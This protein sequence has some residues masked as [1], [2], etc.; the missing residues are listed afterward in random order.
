[1]AQVGYYC[2]FQYRQYQLKEETRKNLFKHLPEE[3]FSVFKL[4][5]IQQIIDWKGN[6]EFSLDGKMYDL[7]K[8]IRT[9][10][11]ETILYAVADVNE[12]ALMAKYAA[13]A[14]NNSAKKQSV[15]SLFLFLLYPPAE[16]IVTN[17]LTVHKHKFI[18]PLSVNTLKGYCTSFY[19]PPRGV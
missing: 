7:V 16:T 2:V 14:H 9:S 5:L 10:A 1:M 8:T 17:I 6:D 4:S 12:D 11:G 15:T 18:V 13:S 3:E 19:A